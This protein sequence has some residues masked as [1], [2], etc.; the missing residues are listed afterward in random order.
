MGG[1]KEWDGAGEAREEVGLE[2]SLR[3]VQ[4]WRNGVE[5]LRE[6]RGG[7]WMSEGARGILELAGG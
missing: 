6:C 7:S 3:G 4:P 2:R 1:R 5:S